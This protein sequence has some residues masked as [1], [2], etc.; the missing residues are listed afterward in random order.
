MQHFIFHIDFN[1]YF[2]TVEQQAN[3][4]LRGKPIGVTGGDRLSRTVLGAASVEAKRF[5]IK[6]GM[7]IPQALKL[8]P[9]LI[10]VKGDCDKYLSCTKKFLNILKDYSPYV[11]VFSIDEVF[12]EFKMQ[13][14]KLKI[15]EAI[16]IAESIK[17]RIKKEVGEWVSCSI[18]IS[19]NKLIAKMAGSLYKPD[20]LVV[21]LD[22]IAAM[23]ILDQI[24]L[25]E[26]CGIGF[27][28]KNRLNNIGIFTFSELRKVPLELL[29]ASFKS[30]GKVLYDMARGIDERLVIPFYEKAE[31]KSIGH[32]HTID[33]DTANPQEIKQI[34]LK[35][36]ELIGRRLR[37]KKLVGKT[38]VC[39]YRS[40]FQLSTPGVAAQFDHNLFLNQSTSQLAAR[41]NGSQKNSSSFQ[42]AGMQAKIEFTSDGLKIFEGAWKIFLQIWDRKEIRM[43]GT[44]V[45]NL[46]S[47]KPQNLSLLE[48]ERRQEKITAAMDNINDRFGEFTLQRAVLLHS[49][50]IYRKPNPFLADRRFKL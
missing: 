10:L 11:E 21:I 14:S 4:R 37:A 18:G 28:I 25:D 15:K 44:S 38:V 1:S 3:P 9:N 39:Y 8:C 2:A 30:Y 24:Q 47:E 13:N 20:G 23:R 12:I 41:V 43:I 32:R 49:Q 17:D 48:D 34:L 45:S 16:K 6:T 33:H 19:Y 22:E 26:V 35:L 46:K 29:L 50:K 36:T 31:V 7:T 40:T 42:G 27:R 5:G